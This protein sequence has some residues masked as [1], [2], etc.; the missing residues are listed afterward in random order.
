MLMKK[1]F[2]VFV[3]FLFLSSAAFAHCP[4][5][6]G[7]TGMAVATARFYG[8]N[9][10]ITGLFVGV[11]MLST[12]LWVHIA[13]KKRNKGKNYVPLQAPAII[14]SSILMMLV[15]FYFTGN[16]AGTMFGMSTIVV[17]TLIGSFVSSVTFLLH[18]LFRAMNNNRNYVPF[19]PILLVFAAAFLAVL[20][21]YAGGL[22]V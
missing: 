18:D 2:F 22:I 16:W 1:L 11:F 15:T 20:G 6:V 12:A 21:L 4:L 3:S 9:D 10:M 8:I 7:A 14:I 17:G 5:C 19:Q 13:L